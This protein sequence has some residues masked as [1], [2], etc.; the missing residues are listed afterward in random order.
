MDFTFRKKSISTQNSNLV[1]FS[2]SD[3]G[4]AILQLIVLR[5][6]TAVTTGALWLSLK[7]G[8]GFLTE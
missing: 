8:N 1:K 7:L 6:I 3:I 5:G 4:A 2:E